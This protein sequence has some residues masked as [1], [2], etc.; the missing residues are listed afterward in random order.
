MAYPADD[1]APPRTLKPEP[2]PVTPQKPIEVEPETEVTPL[3]YLRQTEDA[4]NTYRG[5]S[6]RNGTLLRPN[7]D[8]YI[9][10][11]VDPVAG[12]GSSNPFFRDGESEGGWTL[13]T[14]GARAAQVI[15]DN[16]LDAQLE[17]ERFTEDSKAAK[18]ALG[19]AR[20]Y[21]DIEAPKSK[22]IAR[23]FQDFE[24]RA[25]LL[26]DLMADE[27]QY[28]MRA[29]DQNIQNMS[30][31]KE[32]G[33]GGVPGGFYAKQPMSS[34]L[35]NILAPSLPEYVRPDYRLNQSVGLPGP[36]GFDDQDYNQFG[37]PQFAFGTDPMPIQVPPIQIRTWPWGGR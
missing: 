10:E 9:E 30:A 11:Y 15:Y 36:Q 29:D 22:E 4:W 5:E 12:G 1:T 33:L 28:G 3:S 16:Y 34:A 17:F 2:A 18:A 19:T 31:Q 26:Y 23:Q 35:S 27:Q 32:L 25:T 6:A 8:G 13:N 7:E 21:A 14:P 24:N 37:F 20:S